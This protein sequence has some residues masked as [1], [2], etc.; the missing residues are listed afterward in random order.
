[1]RFDTKEKANKTI[2]EMIEKKGNRYEAV[3]CED[4]WIV[5]IINGIREYKFVFHPSDSTWRF[6][7]SS[8]YGNHSIVR[9]DACDASGYPISTK[10]FIEFFE[11]IFKKYS[12]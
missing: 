7:G 1:M 6:S 2:S 11:T 4:H 8:S 12:A 5:K 9:G 3:N 10:E